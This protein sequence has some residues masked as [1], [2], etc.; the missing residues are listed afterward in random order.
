MTGGSVFIALNSLA[1]FLAGGPIML[2]QS[3]DELQKVRGG[4]RPFSLHGLD[5][6]TLRVA[7]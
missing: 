2:P 5:S 3:A 6:K 1:P 4:K 7:G